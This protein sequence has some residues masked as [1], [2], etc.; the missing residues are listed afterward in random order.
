MGLTIKLTQ[1]G[2]SEI[3]DKV[4]RE[5]KTD[6]NGNFVFDKVRKL[7]Y[8]VEVVN[9]GFCWAKQLQRVKVDKDTLKDLV[10]EQKGFEAVLESGIKFDATV[11]NLMSPNDKQ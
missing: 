11:Y 7:S 1:T 10:F 4:R 8:G 2:I 6:E 9:E 3:P 5:T